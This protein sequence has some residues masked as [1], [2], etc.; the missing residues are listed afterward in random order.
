M[1]LNKQLNIMYL[2]IF[3][4]L[5]YL[6]NVAVLS[7]KRFMFLNINQSAVGL[8]RFN[9]HVWAG[10]CLSTPL[11]TTSV[12]A[13]IWELPLQYI[14]SPLVS[15]LVT[16]RHECSIHY[17]CRGLDQCAC[18]YWF[19]FVVGWIWLCSLGGTAATEMSSVSCPWCLQE[20]NEA[21]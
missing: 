9:A 5:V 20:S 1:L 17:N 2:C 3:S 12:Q 15:C 7:W 11:A 10:I 14:R 16:V 6:I 13:F 8:A 18:F 21:D 4:Q 19:L